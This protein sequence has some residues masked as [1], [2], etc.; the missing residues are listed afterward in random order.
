MTN[1]IEHFLTNWSNGMKISGSHF[2]DS[3]NA[4]L[5]QIRDTV[6][7]SHFRHNSGLLPMIGSQNSLQLEVVDSRPKFVKI[8]LIQCRAITSEGVRIDISPA[9]IN[10]FKSQL[11]HEAEVDIANLNVNN[12]DVILQIN[13]FDRMV[14]GSPDGN[15][16]P[17]RFKNCAPY[18]KLGILPSGQVNPSS[19]GKFTFIVGKINFIGD[20]GVLDQNYIPASMAVCSHPILMDYFQKLAKSLLEC[21]KNSLTIIQNV[22]SKKQN[23]DLA[24]NVKNTCEEIVKFVADISFEYENAGALMSPFDLINIYIRLAKR[25]RAQF[26]MVLKREEL[27]MYFTKW[28]ELSQ[29]NFENL[30]T[31]TTR[32]S[33]NHNDV[34]EPLK[35]IEHFM[36]QLNKLLFQ[37]S[38]LEILEEKGNKGSFI[39][40]QKD[41]GGGNDGGYNMFA[42]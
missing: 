3:E 28:L 41:I 13:P 15:E 24:N 1:G 18:F 6:A 22:H 8:R 11:L 4:L 21:Q 9:L 33:Y 42:D 5:D 14:F 32:F 16:T 31:E 12:F 39:L 27:V 7:L 17:V 34:Q 10:S 19:Q 25:I 40:S 23:S 37:L 36:S 35:R 38:Q 29:G 26:Q 2:T 20:N 30:I